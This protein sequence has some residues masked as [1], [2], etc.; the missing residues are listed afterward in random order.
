[1]LR[2]CSSFKSSRYLNKNE[3]FKTNANLFMSIN[4]NNTAPFVSVTWHQ[5]EPLGCVVYSHCGTNDSYHKYIHSCCC[6]L[7]CN[8]VTRPF[9][10]FQRIIK[11]QKVCMSFEKSKSWYLFSQQILWFNFQTWFQ[12]FRSMER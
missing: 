11:S 3:S 7:L 8:Y 9:G 10:I 2:F 1:M 4:N 5:K 6:C 12:I